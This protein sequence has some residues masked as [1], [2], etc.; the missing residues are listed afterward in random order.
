[1][2]ADTLALLQ[3]AEQ[4]SE[5]AALVLADRLL[6]CPAATRL[7]VIRRLAAYRKRLEAGEEAPHGNYTFALPGPGP[8][9][10]YRQTYI[11][12]RNAVKLSAPCYYSP[13][14]ERRHHAGVRRRLRQNLGAKFAEC[15]ETTHWYMVRLRTPHAIPV[16]PGQEYLYRPR[17]DA[18]EHAVMDIIPVDGGKVE[19]AGRG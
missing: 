12:G 15:V 18:G 13:H 16:P 1:M 3:E 4:G 14:D 19:G 8:F 10:G 9:G 6:D 7:A 17:R 5:A 2:D 11:D